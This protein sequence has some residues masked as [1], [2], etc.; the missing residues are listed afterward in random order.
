VSEPL[1]L[2]DYQ[3]ADIERIRDAFRGGA[4]APLYQLSTGGGKTV[5][6]AHVIKSAVAK[7]TRTLV[8]AHRRELIKQASN[9]L[10]ALGVPHG[11]IAAGQDRDHD[12]QV[13]VA[14]IQTVARRL[15]TLPQFQLIVI[16]EAHHAVASTWAKLLASQPDARLLGVTATPARLD[17]KGLGKHCGGSFDA[18]VCGPAMQ[19]LVDQGYLA[20]C[21]VFIPSATINTTG[22][23]TI[24]G[25][26][27]EHE[28]AERA[29]GVTGDAVKEFQALPEGT[30][31]MAFCVTVAHAEAV[32]AA[33]QDA[34]Y[35]ATAVHGGLDKASRDDAIQ[36]LQDG[37]TQVLTSCEIISEG[38]DVP[39]VGC[40]I[41]LRPTQSLTMCLQQ[42]GRGMRPKA[43][44]GHL[45]VLDH[46]RNCVAHGLPTEPRDWS[47]DGVTKK[48][49]KDKAAPT[50][51]DCIK[52]GVLNSPTRP[53]CSNCGALKPWTCKE[54]GTRNRGEH[55][56]CIDCGAQRPTRK[57]LVADNA[58]MQELVFDQ[59]AHIARMTYRQLLSKPRTE[60]ELAAYARAHNYKSGWVWWKLKEQE[61]TF[62]QKE[63]RA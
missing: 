33:F 31:G 8:L 38:L 52:C 47:L 49:D 63:K 58:P 22:L 42:I 41:L 54:C 15:D 43:D 17:G 44:G 40:V 59:Y 51:W 25:D 14:S 29:S 5:V 11:I 2:R 62:P 23:R 26:Y 18:I 9:K 27:D 55:N 61:E 21:K 57:L 24:A 37:R 34:G 46:A 12:A 10:T 16:D 3:T 45:T 7:G 39:S 53:T 35:R 1:T 50:P 6:F 48:N 13:I 30:T 60:A 36:G 19:D 4:K 20:P 56:R 32:A 28:L